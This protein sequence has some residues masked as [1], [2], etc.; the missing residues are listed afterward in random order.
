[1]RFVKLILISGMIFFLVLSAISLL[2]P[3]H[4]RVSRAINIAASRDNIYATV[5]DLRTWDS[6]NE[7]IRSTPLTGKSFS[8]PSRG[9]GAAL[10]S[11]QLVVTELAS[12]PDGVFFGWDQRGG[13]YFEG[14][15]NLLQLSPD[16]LTV[17]AWFDFH[18]RWYP[19]EK[20]GILVYDKKMGPVMEE[21]LAGLKRFM[22]NSP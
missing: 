14:G 17:Q 12:S 10:R 15:Y 16:S 19:W 8:S 6:W 7:F 1:M 2:F 20:L 21:S 9:K 11:D 4:L 3:S 5:S 18:F 22:E 13:K